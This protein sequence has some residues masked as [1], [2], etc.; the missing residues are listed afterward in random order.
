MAKTVIVMVF[1][2]LLYHRN[3]LLKANQNVQDPEVGGTVVQ[4]LGL[5]AQSRKVL[6]SNFT[7]DRGLSEW[8]LHV[9][10]M[11]VWLSVGYFGF[12]HSPNAWE[13]GQLATLNCP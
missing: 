7:A 1:R 8:R 11:P 5:S 2:S 3:K 13:L 4:W 10:P 6:G 12:P 9:F